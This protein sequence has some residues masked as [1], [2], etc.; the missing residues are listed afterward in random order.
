M[1]AGPERSDYGD[2]IVLP[3][4]MTI[5]DPRPQVEVGM[6]R[7]EPVRVHPAN[8]WPEDQLPHRAGSTP[9]VEEAVFRAELGKPRWMSRP[10]DTAKGLALV[11]DDNDSGVVVV[12]PDGS[13]IPDE[14]SPTGKL[15]APTSDLRPV[16]AAGRE[17]ALRF[18]STLA[19]P[20]AA[21]GALPGLVYDL[22]ANVGHGGRF[23]YQR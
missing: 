10:R 15:M 3:F 6:S 2:S 1:T 4:A 7:L 20:E 8:G 16:A 19:T 21:I 13:T 14:H 11:A 12:L 22:N 5:P 9:F 23:D 18:Q 17:A